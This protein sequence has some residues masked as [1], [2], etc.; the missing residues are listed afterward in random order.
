MREKDLYEADSRAA[1]KEDRKR[2][3]T[4]NSLLLEAGRIDVLYKST[5]DREFQDELL[6]EFNS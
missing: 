4:L 1:A 6:K 5:T 3:N 2:I